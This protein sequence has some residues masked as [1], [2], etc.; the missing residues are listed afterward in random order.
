MLHHSQLP[1]LAIGNHMRIRSQA[2]RDVEG[3]ELWALNES[4]GKAKHKIL[5][6]PNLNGASLTHGP[7]ITLDTYSESN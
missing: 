4:W 5:Q 3:A 6:A 7:P 1:W 2:A